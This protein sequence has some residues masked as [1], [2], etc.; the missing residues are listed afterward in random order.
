[1]AYAQDAGMSTEDF[2][3]FVYRACKLDLV[4]PV[5]A[6]KAVYDEQQRLIDLARRQE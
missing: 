3:D 1:M 2:T 5:A 4:D 6:W